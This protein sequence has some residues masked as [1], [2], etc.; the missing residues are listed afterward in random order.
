MLICISSVSE[1]AHAVRALAEVI[2]S[3]DSK[4]KLMSFVFT[5]VPSE[6]FFEALL[7][8]DF[9]TSVGVEYPPCWAQ[10]IHKGYLLTTKLMNSSQKMVIELLL[11]SLWHLRTQ[12]LEL[13]VWS[14]SEELVVS[15]VFSFVFLTKLQCTSIC[16][17]HITNSQWQ[18]SLTY[19]MIR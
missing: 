13:F 10:L 17:L 3:I 14:H 7:V 8:P 15:F 11:T 9:G 18:W 4:I 16:R 6:L 2:A 5:F 19:T 1:V 12:S